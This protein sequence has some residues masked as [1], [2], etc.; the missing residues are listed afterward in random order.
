[1]EDQLFEQFHEVFE[2]E[3]RA[4]SFDRLRS[5][6]VRNDWQARGARRF[7]LALPRFALRVAAALALV[8]LAVASVGAFIA[9][10]RYAHRSVPVHPAPFNVRPSG[11]AVCISGCQLAQVTFVSASIGFVLE[12]KSA[13]TCETTCLPQPVSL[14]RTID[15]GAHWQ[16]LTTSTI[17]CCQ[18]RLI[19]SADGKQLL[20]FGSSNNSTAFLYS[21]DGGA[22]WT[23]HALPESA[24]I[25]PILYFIDPRDGWVLAQE[26]SFNVADLFRTTDAGANWTLVGRIDLAKQFGLDL[27]NGPALPDGSATH[28]LAGQLVFSAGSVAWFVSQPSC[29]S[30]LGST[31]RDLYGVFRSTDGG[32][33]WTP[34]HLASPEGL[35]G[36]GVVVPSVTFFD[37]SRGVSELVV[38]PHSCDPQSGYALV[39]HR[40]VYTTTD[41]GATWST[42]IAVPQP[43]LYEEMRYIDL[44]RWVGWPYGG[45]WISTSDAGRHW[46]V[47]QSTGQFGDRLAAGQGL[48]QQLP[49]DYPLRAQFGFVDSA[50]GWAVPYQTAGDPNKRGVVLYLTDDGGSTWRPASLPELA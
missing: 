38:N 8:L 40:Y 43:S 2:M 19:A 21:G 9:I 6:L 28:A 50:H 25:S 45:G 12:S 15:A 41:G 17:D 37:A 24:W 46:T 26:Q 13:T 16:E 14:F 11:T 32:L 30:D 47:V 36:S 35:A 33:N 22:T 49:A 23:R 31:G 4:G 5:V 29:V 27:A 34:T 44:Q 7:R 48:P 39:E 1:M 20:L 10:N 3:P 18:V 42:P